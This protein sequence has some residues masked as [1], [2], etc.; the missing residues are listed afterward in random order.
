M[1]GYSRGVTYVQM[2][3]GPAHDNN[4]LIGGAVYQHCQG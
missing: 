4:E 3:G 1:F 2:Q